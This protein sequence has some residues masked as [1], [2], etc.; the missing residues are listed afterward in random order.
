[1]VNLGIGAVCGSGRFQH[2]LGWSCAPSSLLFCSTAE[3]ALLGLPGGTLSL[4][5]CALGELSFVVHS[6]RQP[7]NFGILLTGLGKLVVLKRYINGKN[8]NAMHVPPVGPLLCVRNWSVPSE[9]EVCFQAKIF[10]QDLKN[11]ICY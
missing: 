5:H 7:E 2:L 1:M 11:K 10:M 9:T 4:E 6:C 3:P 8:N